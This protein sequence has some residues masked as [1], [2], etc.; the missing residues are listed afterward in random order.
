MRRHAAM[1]RSGL[2][3]ADQPGQLSKRSL[4]PPATTPALRGVKVVKVDVVEQSEQGS[5][6]AASPALFDSVEIFKETGRVRREERERSLR[7]SP[8]EI[9]EIWKGLT[10]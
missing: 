1:R 5:L 4:A 6:S 3:S 10:G 8:D 9:E 2:V 7:L